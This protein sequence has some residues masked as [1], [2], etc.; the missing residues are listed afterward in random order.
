MHPANRAS[1]SC[2]G[3]SRTSLLIFPPIKGNSAVLRKNAVRVRESFDACFVA[4]FKKEPIP[5]FA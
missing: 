1:Y 2:H 5:P 3:P 4:A